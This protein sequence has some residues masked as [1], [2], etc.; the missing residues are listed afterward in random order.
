VS[1]SATVMCASRS[2]VRSA[3]RRAIDPRPGAA[4]PWALDLDFTT[5]VLDPRISFSRA[6]PAWHFNSAGV[7]VQAA[8]NAP[9][10]AFD[11]ATLQPLGLQMEAVPRTNSITNS[12]NLGSTA[13]GKTD[14]VVA[15]NAVGITGTVN[16]AW[17]ITEGS[18][19]T[20]LLTTVA[21]S[22]AAGSTITGYAV[23]KRG[24]TDWVRLLVT[25]SS[26]ADG[27]S[28]W[29]NMSTVTIGT[30]SARGAGTLISAHTPANLGNGWYLIAL[31]VRPN[32]TY[33]APSIALCSAVGDNSG[34][35][36]S[37]ST[38]LL[39]HSQLEVGV[40]PSSPVTTTGAAVTNAGE[41]AVMTG[42]NFSSWW[43]ALSGTVLTESIGPATFADFP[44][45]ACIGNGTAPTEEMSLYVA[46]NSST[47]FE[48]KSQSGAVQALLIG[49][50]AAAGA[51]R[52]SA[53]AWQA[54]DFAFSSNGGAAVT[55]S[56][57]LVPVV[58][59]L[60]FAS[61]VARGGGGGQSRQF[62]R[63]FRYSPTR[64]T[65]EQLQQ[66]TA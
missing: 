48:V 10:F 2:A 25:D 26:L 41:I 43:N 1:A 59:R 42:G 24:N 27:A 51:V 16:S 50:L 40:S 29:I 49:G 6:S 47:R 30:V 57:G 31:T 56:S 52:K 46:N 8:A 9:R 19:G 33:I 18:A 64:M 38:Y 63:R 53:F 35:R 28:L 15:Q 45:I 37:G 13:W 22:V 32:G 34:V 55:D 39:S 54:N 21:A 7:L 65:N 17:T 62:I 3:V 60:S 66:L 12:G 44:A 61:F 11:P 14:A 58:D 5:G 20:A 36:V 4:S 23:L